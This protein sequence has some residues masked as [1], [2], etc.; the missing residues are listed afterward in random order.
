MRTIGWIGVPFGRVVEDL[1]EQPAG[2]AGARRTL[3][4][5]HPLGHLDDAERRQLA[6]LGIEHGG[7][8]PDQLLGRAGIGDRDQ[9]PP[10]ERRAGR[11]APPPEAFQRCTRYGFS[12]SNSRA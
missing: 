11:H 3:R 10:G 7:A 8:E 4:Q 9:D 5:R 6:G 2:V 12:S 1:L